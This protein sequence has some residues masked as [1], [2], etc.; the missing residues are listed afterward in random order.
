V[1]ITQTSSIAFAAAVPRYSFP[2]EE[3]HI[4]TTLVHSWP[5]LVPSGA[6]AAIRSARNRSLAMRKQT[7]SCVLVI[8]HLYCAG[9]DLT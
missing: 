7:V 9:K 3:A 1:T 5:I 6:H 2:I 4:S 8:A